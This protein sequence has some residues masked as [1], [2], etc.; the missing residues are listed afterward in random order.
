MEPISC[1][2]SIDIVEPWNRQSNE[3]ISVIECHVLLMM[4]VE[5]GRDEHE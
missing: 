4:N 3:E 5:H 1:T 2:V